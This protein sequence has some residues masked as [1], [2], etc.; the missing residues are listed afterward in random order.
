MFT[1]NPIMLS[2]IILEKQ[3]M[4]S[5]LLKADLININELKEEISRRF[6]EAAVPGG[7]ST[8]RPLKLASCIREIDDFLEG[9]LPFN[10]ITE[11]GMPL[12]KEGRVLLLK[13]LINATRGIEIR[14]VWVLWVSSHNDFSVFPP[15]WFVKGVS[16]SRMVFTRSAAPAEDL[17]RA[18][19]N[20][21]FKLIVLD[22]PQRFSRDDCFFVNTQA[23]T[24]GQLII[25]LRNFFL[26][27]KRGNVWARLRLNCWKRQ[28]GRNFIL[29]TVKGLPSGQLF[30]PEE[31]LR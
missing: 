27:D 2:L 3:T 24:N 23:R 15:A 17:K 22:S 13:F 5:S 6:P 19:I 8:S 11:F 14:P 31:R 20:P 9:G 28:S 1:I 30:I 4:N 18:L 26:S 7:A 12:G 10:G 29:K 21:L 16:P 25:L